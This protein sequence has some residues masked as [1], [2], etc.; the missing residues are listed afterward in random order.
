MEKKFIRGLGLVGHI[1]DIVVGKT[2][3]GKGFGKLIIQAL[4]DLSH[5]LGGYKVRAFAVDSK[6]SPDHAG[7]R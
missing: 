4:A 1:E 2:A 6:A 5:N 7:L 3:Q